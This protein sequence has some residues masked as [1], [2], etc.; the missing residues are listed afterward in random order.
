LFHHSN[1]PI[2][3]TLS[4]VTMVNSCLSRGHGK[5]DHFTLLID[6]LRTT[7]NELNSYTQKDVVFQLGKYN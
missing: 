1:A 7:N 3:A 5:T 4:M 2:T 6:M